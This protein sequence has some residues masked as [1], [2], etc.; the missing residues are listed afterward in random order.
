MLSPL[1]ESEEWGR[2]RKFCLFSSQPIFI[3]RL[4]YPIT[5]FIAF[6]LFEGAKR[7]DDNYYDNNIDNNDNVR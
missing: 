4:C 1:G 2:V 5:I 7:K 6:E 3:Q